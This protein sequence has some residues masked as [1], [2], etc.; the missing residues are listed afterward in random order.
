MRLESRESYV[1]ARDRLD[2]L[3]RDL[4]PDALFSIADSLFAAAAFLDHHGSVR[5]GLADPSAP[6]ASRGA[7]MEGL[8]RGRLDDRAVDLLMGMI[9]SRWSRPADIGDSAEALGLEAVL[10]A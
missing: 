3:A 9:R 7:L 8:F 5:R 4:G 6:E 2:E 10:A 1:E